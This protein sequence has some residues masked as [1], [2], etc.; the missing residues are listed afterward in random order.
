MWPNS[1]W[2][3]REQRD[4]LACPGMV[5]RAPEREDA[6]E[7]QRGRLGRG[8]AEKKQQKDNEAERRETLKRTR[9]TE[10]QRKTNSNKTK[11]GQQRQKD[12]GKERCISRE[13]QK[14]R[15]KRRKT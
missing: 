5:P 10:R 9:E 4:T 14:D 15:Q 7:R 8:T 3:R 2:P 1:P 13:R 12:R 11:R 6:G